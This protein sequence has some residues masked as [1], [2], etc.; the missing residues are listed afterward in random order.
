MKVQ[1]IGEFGL[2]ELLAQMVKKAGCGEGVVLGIGDDA[3]AW[4]ILASL[5]LA[6]TDS[7]VEGVHFI[8][9]MATGRALGWKALAVNLSDIAAMGGIPQHALITLGLPPD[10]E[11]EWVSELYE[12]MLA[13]AQRFG[14]TIVGGD[15]VRAPQ[16]IISITLLGKAGL[17]VGRRLPV[18]TRSSA[19][20]GERIAVTGWLGAA[21]AGLK[22]LRSPINGEEAVVSLLK[23]A[24]F[25]P[26]PRVAEGQILVRH[27]VRAAI[28]V[29]D[30]LMSDLI[31]LCQASALGARVWLDRVPVHPAVKAVFGEEALDLALAGGEDYELLFTGKEATLDELKEALPV[32][33]TVIGEVVKDQPGRVVALNS[34]GREVSWGRKGWDHLAANG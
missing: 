2:I 24:H 7:L 31:R 19:R 18:L 15:V 9:G 26:Q 11:V 12:G 34:A 27:G 14:V 10:T 8:T 20:V 4:R 23:E 21:A 33:M 1:E 32:Q 6:T 17:K 13:M 30:G 16:I 29:S 3:A 28:D 22:L 5:Q 25:R